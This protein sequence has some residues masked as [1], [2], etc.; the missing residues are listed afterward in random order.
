MKAEALI[1]LCNRALTFDPNR[2]SNPFAFYTTAIHNSFIQ[3]LNNE[4]KQRNIRDKLLI[5]A[6][7][8]PS[9]NYADDVDEDRQ[10]IHDRINNNF[11][12]Y[13]FNDTAENDSSASDELV[14]PDIDI[15]VR[16]KLAG[17]N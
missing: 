14:D 11:S 10:D 4:K 9:Y 7:E 3:F 8:L 17:F 13:H 2:T 16:R 12:N 5:E 1:N 6:G 15:I